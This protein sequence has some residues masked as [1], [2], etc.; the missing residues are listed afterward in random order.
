MP[1]RKILKSARALPKNSFCW[2]RIYDHSI[3][4][5]FGPFDR[6]FN[7]GRRGQHTLLI[8][9]SGA[10]KR[11]CASNTKEQYAFK[12]DRPSDQT[13]EAGR[14]LRSSHSYD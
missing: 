4:W 8:K 2:D 13:I 11:P 9:K 12:P 3:A 7:T 1:E 5:R 6:L 10:T 14:D